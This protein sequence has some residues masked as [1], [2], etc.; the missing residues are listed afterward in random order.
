MKERKKT[1]VTLTIVLMNFV[2]HIDIAITRLLPHAAGG[3]AGV[4]I[5][6]V[7]LLRTVGDIVDHKGLTWPS[8]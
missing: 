4:G 1:Y 6:L 2:R 3:C 8:H 5:P 7:L